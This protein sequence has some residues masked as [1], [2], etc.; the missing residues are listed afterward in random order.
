MALVYAGLYRKA[1]AGAAKAKPAGDRQHFCF[2][3]AR[4]QRAGIRYCD[5]PGRERRADSL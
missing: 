3:A 4:F 1:K 5:Y 2:D